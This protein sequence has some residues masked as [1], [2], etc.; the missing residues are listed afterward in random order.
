MKLSENATFGI[1]FGSVAVVML[2]IGLP[3]YFKKQAS[4]VVVNK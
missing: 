2:A 1:V 3:L 4:S